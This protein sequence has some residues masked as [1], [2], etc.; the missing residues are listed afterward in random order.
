MTSDL[1]F[2]R[3]YATFCFLDVN[4]QKLLFCKRRKIIYIP[5]YHVDLASCKKEKIL[6]KTYLRV[7]YCYKVFCYISILPR[8]LFMI[9][10]KSYPA[11]SFTST[12]EECN[13]WKSGFIPLWPQRVVS[14]FRN[15]GALLRLFYCLSG[16]GPHREG[17]NVCFL[18][19]ALSF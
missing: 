19:P 16:S 14:V 18:S 15:R 2:C 13:C 11:K 10:K 9:W 17:F 5:V 4:S 3:I 12:M 1:L 8:T 6:S 7:T